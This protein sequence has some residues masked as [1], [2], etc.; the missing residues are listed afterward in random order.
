MNERSIVLPNQYRDSVALLRLAA[1]LRERDG[2]EDAVVV[3]ATPANLR[4]AHEAGF[5]IEPATTA[6]PNDLFVG[7]V[8]SVSSCEGALVWLVSA[9]RDPAG[10]AGRG[11]PVAERITTLR[12]AVR[13]TGRAPETGRAD[14]A[15]T[16]V[17]AI[18]VPGA[19][20]AAEARK[21]LQCGMHVFLFSDN[22]TVD[23]EVELK[24]F[25]ASSGLL[26]MGPDC[27]TAL[28]G[29]VPLGF[30]NEV[31][32]G[33]IAV[34]GASGTGMQEVLCRIHNRGSGVAH[35]IGC[36][37]RDL[38]IRVG[39]LTMK[40]ALDLLSA[41][42]AVQAL[43]IVSKPPA[44]EVL[45]ELIEHLQPYVHRS[46]PVILACP[47]LDPDDLAIPGLTVAASLRDAADRAVDALEPATVL[48]R[49]AVDA[50]V[51]D[52]TELE[53]LQRQIA[54][55]GLVVG[56][57]SGGTLCTEFRIGLDRSGVRQRCIDFGDDA[58]T[59]GRPHPMIDPTLRD[60]EVL[61]SLGDPDV[62]VVHF[63]VVLGH[64]ASPRPIS[65]LLDGLH[66]HRVGSGNSAGSVGPAPIV[67]AHVLGT[68]ADPQQ[69][70]DI[71]HALRDA[72]VRVF[73]T[74]RDA[75]DFVTS[76]VVPT[77]G[78]GQ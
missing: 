58:Y 31:R 18:S 71:E 21:A 55:R 37:G 16:E 24:T 34:I 8:G 65:G 13:S 70:S 25:G 63:D 23:D 2:I 54:G 6:S 51:A 69:R 41:D 53:A 44:P 40:L 36:G 15:R 19:Y 45:L 46:M 64:G 5:D 57:F 39:G 14:S 67:T 68:D 30:A 49:L 77:P 17:A 11:G 52:H 33:P 38:D 26:V 4:Q 10:A 1:D 73:S 43:V 61:R 42:P 74:N 62:G 20:A 12:G 72:G 22:V 27:G 50:H 29:G 66:S 35:A 59:D 32:P 48:P 47:G 7:V 76:A 78:A 9:L 60:A 28:I 3:M 56:A 75:V